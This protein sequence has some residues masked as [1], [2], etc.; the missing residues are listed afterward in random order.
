[1]FRASEAYTRRCERGRALRR[2]PRPISAPL[3]SSTPAPAHRNTAEQASVIRLT[4][5]RLAGSPARRTVAPPR[6]RRGCRRPRPTE[7]TASSG[8]ASV[9]ATRMSGRST[10]G[11]ATSRSTGRGSSRSP[12][13][14]CVPGPGPAATTTY[15]LTAGWPAVPPARSPPGGG[16]RAHPIAD[17]QPEARPQAAPT[18]WKAAQ[19]RGGAK[20]GVRRTSAWA[21]RSASALPGRSRSP[22]QCA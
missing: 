5:G 4:A 22:S 13:L 2:I 11:S 17:S 9:W 19:K 8:R 12:T 18:S 7:A 3:A 21:R 20:P 15:A 16:S 1:M 6:G 14:G 10:G